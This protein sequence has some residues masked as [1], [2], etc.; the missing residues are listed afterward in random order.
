MNV[1]MKVSITRYLHTQ[2]TQECPLA[3]HV[4]RLGVAANM[5]LTSMKMLC[6]AVAFS[7]SVTVVM[8]G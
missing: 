5:S 4:L 2:H 3:L 1:H 6:P 7:C 8:C